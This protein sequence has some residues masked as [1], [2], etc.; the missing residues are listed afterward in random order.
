MG[1]KSTVKVI[2]VVDCKEC[3]CVK[4][5]NSIIE[6][7]THSGK[8]KQATMILLIGCH[9]SQGKAIF[10]SPSYLGSKNGQSCFNE[11]DWEK[12]MDYSG[13]WILADNG[14]SGDFVITKHRKNK[15]KPFTS[16]QIADNLEIDK[17]RIIIENLIG[18]CSN[19]AICNHQ[20]RVK[21]CTRI[22]GVE[23]ML[24]IHHENWTIV[25]GL[26]NK[27]TSVRRSNID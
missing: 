19:Y 14:F 6:S 1:V 23:R 4:S 9:P 2:I 5:T 11:V 7:Q 20:W 15:F 17:Y 10:L 18:W 16:Q 26:L 27:Y 21:W 25:V 22:S 12:M 3:G 8:Y 24:D 13:E